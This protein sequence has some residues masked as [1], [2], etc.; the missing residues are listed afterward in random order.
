[1]DSAKANDYI[2]NSGNDL[3]SRKSV[4][5][6]AAWRAG[7]AQEYNNKKMFYKQAALGSV[8]SAIPG[9]RSRVEDRTDRGGAGC[10]IVMF[11]G[12]SSPAGIRVRRV[13]SLFG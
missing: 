7:G 10:I 1:M 11:G 3:V 13:D 8:G 2:N 4:W 9:T 12:Y 6:P 5:L